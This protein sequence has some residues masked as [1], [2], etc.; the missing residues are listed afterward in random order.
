MK[1]IKD[2]KVISNRTLEKGHTVLL[3]QLDGK[4]PEIFPGQFVEVLVDK[5]K[6]TF[7]RRPFSVHDVDFSKNIISLLIKKVGAGTETLSQIKEGETLN[8][9]FPL[10][11]GFSLSQNKKVLLV[12]GG[13]G[14][15]PLLFLARCLKEKNNEVNILLGGRS[16]SDVLETEAFG[17][18]GK[19]FVSTEDGSSCEK[20]MVTTNTVLKNSFDK[21]YAC[22]PEPMLKAVAKIARERNTD[23]EVSLEN[24]MACGVG[25][26]LCCV[27][28]TVK[29]N[30]CVCTEGPVFNINELKWQ[31]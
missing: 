26:C 11:K 3:L 5:S 24:T 17:K 4:M 25:A 6:S 1:H 29:G 23:C 14:I 22:G 19:I 30:Q 16:K 7:L 9:I 15:A 8:M 20:G 27:T 21:I 12:G 28:E 13:C 31:I 18:L 10:G 2:F